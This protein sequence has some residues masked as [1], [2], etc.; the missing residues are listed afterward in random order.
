[1]TVVIVKTVLFY[2]RNYSLYA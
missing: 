1:V 2:L